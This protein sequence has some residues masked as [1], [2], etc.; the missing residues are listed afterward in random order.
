MPETRVPPSA[1]LACP[2]GV[3]MQWLLTLTLSGASWAVG[4]LNG[5]PEP[6]SRLR[7]GLRVKP[8]AAPS[9]RGQNRAILATPM[10]AHRDRRNRN[11]TRPLHWLDRHRTNCKLPR[12]HSTQLGNR[13][14]QIK[15]YQTLKQKQNLKMR[16]LNRSPP[17]PAT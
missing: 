1:K 14:I 11:Q 4:L 6:C 8:F 7:R 16:I 15:S 10:V 17:M 2:V 3:P 13:Y 5:V 9:N 12:L